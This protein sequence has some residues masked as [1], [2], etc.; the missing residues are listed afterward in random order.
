[1]ATGVTGLLPSRL[2]YIMD[3]SSSYRFLIDTGAEISVI[4][5][6]HSDRKYRQEGCNLLAVN[7]STIATYGKRS[8]T[9]D[10]GLRRTFRWVFIIANVQ[11]PILGADFLRQYSLSVDMKHCRLVDA[12]TQLRVQGILS[13]VS[14]PSPTVCHP[15][16]PNTFTAIMTEYP[17]VLQ[18][19]FHS[20]TVDHGITHHILTSGPPIS[21]RTRRLPRRSSPLPNKNSSIC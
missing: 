14:S 20:Q 6:S 2:F 16:P 19:H 9:L 8:L 1:M 3:K 17:T 12:L 18:P 5:P 4:P 13:Q 21:A 11:S 10:M 7:G 15:Q